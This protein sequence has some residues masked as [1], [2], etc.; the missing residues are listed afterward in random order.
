MFG[1]RGVTLCIHIGDENDTDV[2]WGDNVGEDRYHMHI[3]SSLGALHNLTSV[4]LAYV[5]GE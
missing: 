2:S 1:K 4:I 5:L 3:E